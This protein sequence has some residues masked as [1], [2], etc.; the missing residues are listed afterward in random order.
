MKANHTFLPFLAT[1][2]LVVVAFTRPTYAAT[3][4]EYLNILGLKPAVLQKINDFKLDALS[5][6]VNPLYDFKEELYKAG[7]VAPEDLRLSETCFR[8]APEQNKEALRDLAKETTLGTDLE[9]TVGV[10]STAC[11][12]HKVTKR[13][14]PL[15]LNKWYYTSIMDPAG[16]R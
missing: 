7:K 2:F 1:V 14:S 11:I 3:I 5:A 6:S 16:I 15:D 13:F 8:G 10:Q 9:T 4:F 12:P